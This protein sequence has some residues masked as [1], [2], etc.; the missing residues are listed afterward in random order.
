MCGFFTHGFWWKEQ[1]EYVVVADWEVN[2]HSRI[3]E[4]QKELIPKDAKRWGFN[5]VNG[6]P[7]TNETEPLPQKV[8]EKI[9]LLREMY[10]PNR[11]SMADWIRKNYGKN[12]DVEEWNWALLRT[13]FWG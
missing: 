2:S 5:P 3:K 11:E 9:C 6:E 1:G 7:V 4:Y 13:F 8:R 12:D 10:F